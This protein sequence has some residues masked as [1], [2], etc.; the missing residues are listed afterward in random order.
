VK[1]ESPMTENKTR[2]TTITVSSFLKKIK[3]PQLRK[4]CDTIIEI[5]ESVSKLKPVMWGSAIIG[6]GTRHYVYESGREGDTVIVGFSP[7]KQ[8]IALYL[9][10][11]LEPLRDELS[12]LGKH[13]TGNGC[14][15][16]KSLK[17]V[18]IPVLKNILTKAYRRVKQK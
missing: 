14:L 9:A 2:P 18:D 15:Y 11:G 16:I 1:E 6:F 17:D 8:A 4:D 7:R 5:M 10:G 13:T 12:N 3:D